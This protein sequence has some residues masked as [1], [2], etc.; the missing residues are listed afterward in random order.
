MEGKSINLTPV[1][2]HALTAKVIQGQTESC[3]QG[4][5]RNVDFINEPKPTVSY[6]WSAEGVCRVF[7]VMEAVRDSKTPIVEII[8]EVQEGELCTM[9]IRQADGGTCVVA[10]AKNEK[11]FILEQKDANGNTIFKIE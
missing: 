2:A 1:S 6:S 8:P 5:I 4:W 7:Y 9:T 10:T 11:G 3:I